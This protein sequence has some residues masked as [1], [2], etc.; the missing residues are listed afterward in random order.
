MREMREMRETRQR[1]ERE[2]KKKTA[3]REEE[4][5]RRSEEEKKRGREERK[6]GREG[7]VRS[8]L[9][10]SE[11]PADVVICKRI[12]RVTDPISTSRR[13]RCTNR[14]SLGQWR[15][16]KRRLDHVSTN[17]CLGLQEMLCVAPILLASN[18]PIGFQIM[19]ASLT[20]AK[21]PLASNFSIPQHKVQSRPR[22]LLQCADNI[23]RSDA[24]VPFP[25]LL[26]LFHVLTL[27]LGSK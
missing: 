3:R 16:R 2:R 8:L 1:R 23:R 13:K 25:N 26:H 4:R 6:R 10:V 22:F 17:E 15:I 11:P 27:S 19:Y 21:T 5:H 14:S 9:L 18:S 12:T 24:Q 7:H 20:T